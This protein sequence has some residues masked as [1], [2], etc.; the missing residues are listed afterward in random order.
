MNK[1]EHQLYMNADNMNITKS[2]GDSRKFIL[3]LISVFVIPVLVYLQTIKFGFTYF[4]DNLIILNNNQFL[5]DFSNVPGAFQRDAFIRETGIF[6][7]PLQ[8]LSYMTD[9]LISGG[10]NAWM[11]HLTNILLF[12]LLACVLYFLLRKLNI[13]SIAA[14]TGTMVFC[15][16]PLFV[17]SV[18]WIPARGDLLLSLFSLLSLLFLIEFLNKKR[19]VYL[20]LHG[21][22]FVI[23]LFCKE[24]AIVLPLLYVLYYFTFALK[25][26][27][28]KKYLVLAGGYV[29]SGI[30]WFIIRVKALG[31]F[32]G[33]SSVLN[34]TGRHDKVGLQPL[35]SNV[36]TIP[37][38]LGRFFVPFDIDPVPG[39]SLSMTLTGCVVIIILGFLFYKIK[40][41]SRNRKFF[42]LAWFLLFLLPTMVFKSDD[43]D[44]LDHRFFMPLIGILL[45]VLL[46]VPDKWLENRRTVKL[47]PI[48][49]IFFI[50]SC[51]TYR[52]SRAYSGMMNFYNTAVAR[53][54]RS[55]LAHNNLGAAYL[56][57]GNLQK[58]IQEYSSAIRLKPDYANA[59]SGRGNAYYNQKMYRES[60]EDFSMVIELRS[61]DANTYNN[62][63]AAFCRLGL[64][65]KACPDFMK[66]DELGS[67]SAKANISRYCNK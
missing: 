14:L 36:R 17:S 2:A 65:Y 22:C 29:L 41:V 3:V 30:A 27:P 25:K 44:Y 13:H 45:Y 39:F 51:L 11:F 59:Y 37:E 42:C 40:H 33:L 58:A 57:Q 32:S 64:T 6:Y 54:P 46:L 10:N 4:D 47:L 53:N 52:N 5:S 20:F 26:T 9:I 28:E 62:R 8:T 56:D 7:R 48:F 34:L 16:H 55:V 49:F 21:T 15:V 31:G 38:A 18:A 12:G 24:T 43:I 66:A 60:I 1:A 50:L 63:G 35:L 67:V 19:T 23:A 61:A